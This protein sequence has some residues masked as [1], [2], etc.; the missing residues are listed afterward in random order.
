VDVGPLIIPHTTAAK[1]VKPRKRPFSDPPP[2]VQTAPVRGTTHGE[3]RHD[4]PRPQPTP[5][6]RRVVA[7][8]PKHGGRPLP[9][10]P[11]FAMQ[12]G[13]CIHQRQGFLRV[14]PVRAGQ[15]NRER[16]ALP[17]ADQMALAPALGPIGRIGAG[18]VTPVHRA[19]G[20][21]VHDRSRSINLVAASEPIQQRKVDQIPRA[22]QLPIAEAPPASPIRTRVPARAS[23]KECRCEGRRQCRS[24]TR[25]P[26]TR[27][28]PPF[29]RRGGIGKNGSTRSHNASRSSDA[30]AETRL[31]VVVRDAGHVD[32][33]ALR[34]EGIAALVRVDGQTCSQGSM[35]INTLPKCGGNS[36]VQRRAPWRRKVTSRVNVRQR[37]PQRY[38][39]C[40]H[41]LVSGKVADC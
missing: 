25:D 4:M 26:E 41:P 38:P 24:G 3:P 30:C 22:R 28:R 35:R 36:R 16:H 14:V 20:T 23:A 6:R 27:G 21:T 33:A 15:A 7:A 11:A 32:E 1:L 10:S 8:I 19:V 31:R 40:E 29:R 2:P 5:S 17:V 37:T 39:R 34:A 13:N 9:R 18:L 12:R